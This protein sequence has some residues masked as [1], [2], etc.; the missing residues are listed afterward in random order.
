MM[1]AAMHRPFEMKRGVLDCFWVSVSSLDLEL[2]DEDVEAPSLLQISSTARMVSY[3]QTNGD[4]R[5]RL[6]NGVLAA[7]G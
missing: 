1:Q 3:R 7:A 5:K 6:D 4:M 2:G